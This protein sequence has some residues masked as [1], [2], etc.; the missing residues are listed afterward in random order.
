[1]VGSSEIQGMEGNK[2]IINR[3][4]I[5]GGGCLRSINFCGRVCTKDLVGSVSLGFSTEAVL[6]FLHLYVA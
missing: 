3:D 1:M 2:S 4:F 5:I 6:F